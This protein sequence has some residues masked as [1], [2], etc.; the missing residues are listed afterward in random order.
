MYPSAVSII[1]AGNFYIDLK[2][3]NTATIFY[4]LKFA[5]IKNVLIYII[6]FFSLDNYVTCKCLFIYIYIYIFAS[7]LV[8]IL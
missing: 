4:Y 1:L 3:N 7:S 6:I 5:I 8:T 2:C